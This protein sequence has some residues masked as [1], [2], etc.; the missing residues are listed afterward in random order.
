MASLVNAVSYQDKDLC[1]LVQG[2]I[3][4]ANVPIE[5]LVRDFPVRQIVEL[6][7]V[8]LGLRSNE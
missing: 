2:A 8:V 6:P 4:L 7:A 3:H 5:S 1:F